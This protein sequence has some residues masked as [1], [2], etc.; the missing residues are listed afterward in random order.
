M[1]Y[2]ELDDKQFPLRVGEALRVGGPAAD[3]PL[4]GAGAS[5][6][7][8]AVLER[9]AANQVFIQRATDT[10][11][12]RVNGVRLG[13]EP[14]PL[15]HGDKIAVGGCELLYG[16]DRSSGNTQFVPAYDLQAGGGTLGA[17]ARPTAATGGRL[18]SLMDGREYAVPDAGLT[19]GRD[20]GCEVVVP[21]TEVSR[22]HASLAPGE[23]G[24]VLR[25]TSTNGL[26]VNG[27][28]VETARLLGR[29]DVLR[30]GNE[31]LRFSA[32]APPA[33]AAPA[34][35]LPS[36]AETVAGVAFVDPRPV[37]ATLEII[38]QGVLR[39]RCFELRTPLVHVG[40]GAHNDVVVADE[41]VS[42][43]HA[44]L[45][46]REAGWYVVDMDSTNGTYVAGKRVFGEQA[47]GGVLDVRFGGIKMTFHGA[48]AAEDA[49][50]TRAIAGRA[51]MAAAGAAERAAGRPEAV[52]AG[53]E[54][55]SALRLS[56]WVLVLGAAAI[57][58]AI[59]YLRQGR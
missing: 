46:K 7:V 38:N 44:K 30:V 15:M 42:Q 59:I 6:G 40:R 53:P 48:G 39:G 13:A 51:A 17:P 4:P 27:E 41:S 29:G 32:D 21:S 9:A 37:L 20:A 2:I 18:V 43:T 12:V 26:F 35:A 10:A 31:E 34:A 1:P 8:A 28:R 52:A 19:I 25:D 23:G 49:G 11:D 5:S 50:G 47:L 54:R 45:Q 22:R 58:A 36:L 14:T 3:V 33:A 55:G 56:P 57:G 24:Y 16:D